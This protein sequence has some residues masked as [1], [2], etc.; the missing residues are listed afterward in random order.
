MFTHSTTPNAI[1]I[2]HIL[3]QIPQAPQKLYCK[4]DLRTD[5]P[6]VA[7]VGSRKSTAYGQQVT[8]KIVRGLVQSGVGIVSGLALGTDSW[9]HKMCLAQKGYTVAV[10][11]S[12]VDYV[13]PRSHRQLAEDILTRG[14]AI[15]SEYNDNSMSAIT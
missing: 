2:P 1:A 3:Q 6:L 13:T 11:A 9:A 14:G 7:V 4:G 12:G 15:I 8:E 10:L 5:I